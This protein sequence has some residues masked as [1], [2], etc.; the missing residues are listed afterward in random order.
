M[1]MKGFPFRPFEH[2]GVSA[3]DL[4]VLQ[5]RNEHGMPQLLE[6]LRRLLQPGN[7]LLRLK[8][9]IRSSKPQRT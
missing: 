7:G 9:A 4:P 6:H 3:S 2:Q 1:G 8:N 5:K